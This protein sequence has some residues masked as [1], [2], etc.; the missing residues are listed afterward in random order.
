LAGTARGDADHP[1]RNLAA[2]L[3]A[4][5]RGATVLRLGFEA[6]G[7][8]YPW[9]PTG[10][11]DSE[12]IAAYRH[13]AAVLKAAAPD[14]TFEYDIMCGLSLPTQAGRVD[15]LSA[16]YPGDDVIDLVGCT[17]YDQGSTRAGSDVEWL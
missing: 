7:D 16:R 11:S 10:G 14:V 1:W 13:V 17:L 6:N 5:N 8:W 9:G 2:A 3:T 15:A 12:Y 4:A